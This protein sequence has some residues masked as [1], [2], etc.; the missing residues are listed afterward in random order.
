MILLREGFRDHDG[1]IRLARHRG[2]VAVFHHVAQHVLQNRTGGDPFGMGRVQFDFRIDT[3]RPGIAHF[4][5]MLFA[6]FVDLPENVTDP[7]VIGPDL[8]CGK[9]IHVRLE[10]EV[11]FGEDPGRNAGRC[12]QIAQNLRRQQHG[13]RIVRLNIV[14]SRLIGRNTD[15]RP[16]EKDRCVRNRLSALGIDDH[17][18]DLAGLGF[19]RKRQA[20]GQHSAK[21]SSGETHHPANLAIPRGKTLSLP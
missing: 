10:R 7:A 1:Q 20:Q 17:A 5:I 18:A 12:G 6:M 3:D 4:R 13:R 19:Q 8:C 9:H 16:C 14:S 15:A 21:D 11:D 2:G